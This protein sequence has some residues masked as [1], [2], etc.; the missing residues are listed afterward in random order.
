MRLETV[1]D[2]ESLVLHC[3]G[4]CVERLVGGLVVARALQVFV[5]S[6]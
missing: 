3:P 5:I 2:S 1:T 6:P 4:R